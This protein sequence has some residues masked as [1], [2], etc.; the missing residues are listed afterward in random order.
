MLLEGDAGKEGLQILLV[1][2]ATSIAEPDARLI[3]DSASRYC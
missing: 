1:A 2:L 3:A